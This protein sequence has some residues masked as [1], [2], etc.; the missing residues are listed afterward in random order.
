[1]QSNHE[2]DRIARLRGEGHMF[3]DGFSCLGFCGVPRAALLA[4]V[5]GGTVV[6]TAGCSSRGGGATARLIVP[7]VQPGIVA[8]DDGGYEPARSPAFTD[9]TGG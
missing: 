1:M 8:E 5:L 2:M 9:L 6:F 7:D 3:N 4:I